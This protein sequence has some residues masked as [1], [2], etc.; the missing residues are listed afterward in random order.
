[1]ELTG[2]TRSAAALVGRER[3]CAQIELTLEKVRGGESGTL[4]VRGEAGIGK[5][6]LLRY[7]AE[8]AQDMLVL[9]A[10]GV[11]AEADLA[12][13]GLYGLTRPILR[14]LGDVP[15]GQSAALAGALGLAP[16]TGADRFLVSA[17]VLG[18][19]AA[20]AEER[21][22][23]CLIDDAQWLDDPSADALVFAARRLDADRVAML[24]CARDGEAKRFDARGLPELL[25]DGLDEAL[26]AAVLASHAGGAAPGV[27]ERLVAEAQGNPL[28]LIELPQG[29]SDEQLAGTA[30]LP[31]TIPLTPR[32][33]ALF[34]ER[35]ERLPEPTRTALML[36]AA[37]DTGELT[38]IARAA[39]ALGLPADA[40]DPA[41][42]VELIRV[43][44][45]AISFRHPLVRSA[46]YDRATASDRQ[47]VHA[48][49]AGALSG[50]EHADRRVWHQAMAT[51][52]ADEEVAAALEAS[53]KRARMRVAHASA[54]T[55]FLRAAELSSE[56]DRRTGRLGAAAQAAWDAGQPDRAREAI[57]AALPTATR[58]HRGRLLYLKGM[59]EAHAGSVRDAPAILLEAADAT[60]DRSLKLEMLQEAGEAAVYAGDM[61]TAGDV[62]RQEAEIKPK[63]ERDRFLVAVGT[64]W[65]AAF[66]GGLALANAAFTD[67]LARA[68]SLDDPRAL[69]WAAD[70]AVAWLGPGSGLRYAN[71]AVDVARTRGLLSLLP[72]ALHR[73]A[74]ELIG[75]SRFDL[76]YAAAQEGH[77]LAIDLLYGTGGHLANMATVEAIWGR[78]DEARTHAS[79]ALAIGR[80]SG[81]SL[82]ADSAEMTLAFIELTSGR[83]EEAT[84]RLFSLT[85][86]DRPSAHVVIALH[87]VPDLVEVGVRTGRQDEITERLARY[88]A[89]VITAASESG[90]ALLARCEALL[91][92]RLPDEAFREAIDRAAA[93]APFQRARTELLYGEWLRRERRR[94][95]ARVHL[96]AAVELFHSLGTVPWTQRAEAELRATGETTRKR[97]PS[98]LD[99]LTPQELQVA[100]MVAQGMTNKDI[101]ARLYLSPRTID[102]HLRKVFSKLGIAARSELVRHGLPQR[103]PVDAG[104]E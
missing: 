88:R 104:G 28:A 33:R 91:G 73:Q 55:A 56:Q 12:F 43:Q 52:T 37:E 14:F 51:L 84:D 39:A 18:L 7:A 32:L 38:T 11:E 99:E 30:P 54:A 64:A 94:Q 62:A 92:E 81:S 36:A 85:S 80:Q 61:A 16:S 21:P 26:A 29:L 89:W 90:A 96:R 101:A 46:L 27:R 41:E 35:I 8:R 59:I 5:T 57:A 4:V 65:V 20:A 58:D 19:L 34:R 76:A 63:T 87:A 83:T 79:E 45:G 49:L 74:L 95:E 48:A 68:T 10:T 1:M 70:S 71:Q 72:I 60:E 22:V 15:E 9:R 2:L 25:L 102:Y 50:E 78:N 23:V 47:R 6:A 42:A 82:L 86:L 66:S 44:R 24:F 69:V 100:G 103:A 75:N 93:L 40:L 97:D 67:A 53:A 31:E 13:A 3:E 17:A 77:R 98:T